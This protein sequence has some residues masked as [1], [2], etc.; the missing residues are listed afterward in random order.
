MLKPTSLVEADRFSL[1]QARCLIQDLF[2]PNPLIYW[3]DFLISWGAGVYC[4]QQVRQ[5]SLLETYQ[6]TTG[7]PRQI[8]FFVV[9][10][11]LFYRAAMFIHEL[12]HQRNGQLPVFRVVWNLLCGIPFLIPSFVYY[13]HIDHHRRQHFGTDRDGE[14]LPLGH[15]PAWKILYFL[16]W[17]FIIP[18]VA[19]IRFLMLTPLSWLSPRLRRWIHQHVSSMVMDP[20]YIRPLP[21]RSTLRIIRL[22]ELGCFLWC[23]GI[24]V[25]PPLVLGVWPIPFLIHVYLT[26][27]AVVMLNAIRTLGSHRWY[28]AG[29]QMTF[30]EQLLDSV[31]YPHR[32]WVTEMWGPT[33]TR[34]HALHHLFPSLPYHNLP[35]AHRRLQAQLPADSP[36]HRTKEVTLTAALMD[37]WRR[38]RLVG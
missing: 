14:Y 16:S 30:V 23:L 15:Q 9:S 7:H 37:L 3:A 4:F 32:P 34:Y 8:F 10:S 24:A 12:V 20:S 35:A 25:V 6:A 21:S 18:I 5:A 28:N 31:N 33:G 27:V 38:A 22:Q 13:T 1:T 17:S 36:Y 11:L 2:R 29:G 19:V 26:G